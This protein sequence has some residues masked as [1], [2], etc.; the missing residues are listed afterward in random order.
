[1][2]YIKKDARENFG[3]LTD[4]ISKTNIET[5]GNLNYLI[6]SLCRKFMSESKE[7]YDQY[8]TIIGALES[9]KLEFYRR[10][11]ASYENQK[12]IQNGD[13]YG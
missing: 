1:M 12:I 13:V 6:T 5:A 3:P 8:N 11:V 7:N 4:I 10:R 9:A 2:P